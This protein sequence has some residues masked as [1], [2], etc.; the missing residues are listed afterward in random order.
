MKKQI[1]MVSVLVGLSLTTAA[2]KASGTASN[3]DASTTVLSNKK[4]TYLKLFSH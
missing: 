1:L 2:V 4:E 3:V